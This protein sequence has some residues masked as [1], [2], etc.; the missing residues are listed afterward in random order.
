MGKGRSESDID[1]RYAGPAKDEWGMFPV[2]TPAPRNSGEEKIVQCTARLSRV[3][4]TV[5]TKVR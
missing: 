4:A 1:R 5:V 3:R 2:P